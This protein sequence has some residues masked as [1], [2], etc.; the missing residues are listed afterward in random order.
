MS[1]P[2]DKE[3]AAE[4]LEEAARLEREGDVAEKVV[5]ETLDIELPKGELKSFFDSIGIVNEHETVS[6]LAEYL[7]V[8][9]SHAKKYFTFPNEYVIQEHSVPDIIKTMRNHRRK[10]KGDHRNK[11]NTSPPL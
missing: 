6:K 4:K 10:L 11:M 1:S 7:N 9:P 2:E 8:Q 5:E 3:L